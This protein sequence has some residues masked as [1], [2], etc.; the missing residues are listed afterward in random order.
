MMDSA[1]EMMDLCTKHDGSSGG[2]TRFVKRATLDSIGLSK[3]P[4]LTPAAYC[5]FYGHV[6]IGNAEM[7]ERIARELMVFY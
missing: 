6:S 7:T 2:E 5:T 4:S 1:L 3:G